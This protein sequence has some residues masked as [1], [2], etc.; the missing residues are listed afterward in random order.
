MHDCN[1]FAMQCTREGDWCA[2]AAW[3]LRGSGRR[4]EETLDNPRI[5]GGCA[6]KSITSHGSQLLNKFGLPFLNQQ[7]IA[8]GV[9]ASRAKLYKNYC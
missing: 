6:A 2:R 4:K 9:V 3:G 7:A 5:D 1:D 8:I